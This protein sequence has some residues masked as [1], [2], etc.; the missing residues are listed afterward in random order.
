MPEPEVSVEDVEALGARR[1]AEILVEHSWQDAGLRQTLRLAVA[2]RAT[3]DRLVQSLALEIDRIRS[4]DRFFDW[5]T[6]RTLASE[7]DRIRDAIVHNV[8]PRDPKAAASLLDRFIRLDRNVFE[9]AD[10]SDGQIGGV[11]QQAVGDFG[12]AWA[13]VPDRDPVQLAHEVAAIFLKD[14]Y[15]VHGGIIRAFK[16]ALGSVGLDAL[17]RLLRRDLA[18]RAEAHDG[19]KDWALGRGLKDIADARGDVDAFIAAQ[20]V[21]GTEDAAIAAICERLIAA[22]RLEETLGR[23][24]RAVVPAHKLRELEDLRVQVLDLLG[25]ADEA[26]AARWAAFRRTLAKPTLDAYL[27]RLPQ[28]ERGQARRK[29]VD[30]A[31]DHAELYAA[32]SLL[33]G[34]DLD[35]A[36]GLVLTRIESINGDL[37][38]TLRPVAKALSGRHPVAAILLYR[39]MTD[40]VLARAQSTYY[41]HAVRDLV[42]A[43]HLAAN[44]KDWIGHPSQELYRQHLAAKH[45]Q[46]RSFWDRMSA[47]GLKWVGR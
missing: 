10:D 44:I 20:R 37:Y 47:A 24:E 8:Q 14:S 35:A 13:A 18:H 7:L 27:S 42:A 40:A 1:L 28:E 11:M 26:Q 39:R 29:A 3:G 16:D 32:M 17:E 38:T 9:R 23:L 33:A 36:A 12:R 5:R 19:S 2:S 31:T 6:S 21:A 22:G 4:D 34:L 25:R 45:R 41:E 43:E 46:K 30:I 15:G